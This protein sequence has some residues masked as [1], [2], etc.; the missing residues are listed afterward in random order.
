[1]RNERGQTTVLVLGLSL[2]V[3]AVVGLAVDG[4]RAFLLRRTLQNM[5]DAAAVAGASEVDQS[6]YYSTGGGEVSVE[7]GAA[8]KMASEWLL[9]RG[10]RVRAQV[11]ATPERVMVVVRDDLPATFLGLVGIDSIPV[12]AEASAEPVSGSAGGP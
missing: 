12:A 6:T 1:M 5:A 10:L 4:T 2:V 7:P 11:D 8:Q 3:F 9:R